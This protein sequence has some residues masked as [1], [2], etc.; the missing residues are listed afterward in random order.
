MGVQENPDRQPRRD[1]LPRDRAPRGAWAS[2][3]SPST[4]TP[5]RRAARR[6]CDE[7][8]R[9]GR[10]RPRESYLDSTRSSRPRRRRGA[11]AIHPGYGFLS[12]NED[13]AAACAQGRHRLHRPAARGDRRDGRQVGGQAPDGE[14]RRAAGARLPRR[15]PGRRRC[16]RRKPT[17]IG[18]PVLIKAIGRRRRQGHA[19]RRERKPS[20]PRRSTARKREAKSLVRRRRAC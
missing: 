8:C 5:T 12:E 3:P 7:A 9:I 14:G 16:S 15:R 6:A 17:R 4:P 1:R 11:Q 19:R 18:F 2:A 10:R 20:S 13:F